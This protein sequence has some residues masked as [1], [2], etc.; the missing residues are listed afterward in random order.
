MSNNRFFAIVHYN[1]EMVET[2]V[3]IVFQSESPRKMRFEK[4]ITFRVMKEKI[5][6]KIGAPIKGLRYRWLTCNNPVRFSAI[7]LEDNSD[8][9]IMIAEHES[10][11]I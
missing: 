9:E 2:D 1:G 4:E 10:M 6:E 5:S 7:P 3:G 11:D 8:V